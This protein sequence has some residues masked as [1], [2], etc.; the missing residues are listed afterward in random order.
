MY[1]YI[2]LSERML[3]KQ[4]KYIKY[5][6]HKFAAQ[7]LMMSNVCW[8]QVATTTIFNFVRG[9]GSGVGLYQHFRK[10]FLWFLPHAGFQLI[11][12]SSAWFFAWHNNPICS[13]LHSIL[14]YLGLQNTTKV[15]DWLSGWWYTYPSEKC[16][17][18]GRIIPYMMD[19][20]KCLKPPT[21]YHWFHVELWFQG[22]ATLTNPH[23]RSVSKAHE[24][25]RPACCG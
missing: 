20:K 19:N 9:L 7:C 17:S 23:H 12:W 4:T 13:N 3:I 21:S 8:Y 6:L 5:S 22:G 14:M 2:F 24:G 16:Y 18:M 11:R 15:K 1:K 10:T 25:C